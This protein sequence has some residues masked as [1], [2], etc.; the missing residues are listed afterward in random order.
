MVSIEVSISDMVILKMFLHQSSGRAI[1]GLDTL[2]WA[3][4][5][6]LFPLRNRFDIG[7]TVEVEF[8]QIEPPESGCPQCL[9]NIRTS[10]ILDC[11]AAVNWEKID[12]F[13]LKTIVSV[14]KMI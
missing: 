14:H 4:R 8:C 2:L 3:E 7:V 9:T 1:I 6:T 11:I 10:G 13:N 5:T 12:S